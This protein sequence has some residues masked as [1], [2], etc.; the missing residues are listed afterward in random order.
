[1]Y[2]MLY[3]CY[4]IVKADY[5]VSRFRYAHYLFENGSYEEAM[6]HFLESQVEM[7]YVLSLYPSITIPKSSILAETERF[8][9]ITGD[10][11]DLSRG[12]SGFSD[13]LDSLPQLS[14][15][16]ESA[17]LESK[18]INHNTLMA[19]IKFLQK[20]RFSIV[21]KATAEGTDE[22]VS[23]AVGRHYKSYETSRH[24]KLNK[25]NI[26]TLVPNRPSL[27]IFLKKSCTY[28]LHHMCLICLISKFSPEH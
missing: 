27:S 18:K 11:S 19:L 14:E 23:D 25:V 16:D 28:I 7:T 21:D 17:A 15:S 26:R 5:S 2:Q 13:D 10:A 12:S 24:N 22:V 9:D 20:K 4:E 6:E 1:M 3:I 8:V